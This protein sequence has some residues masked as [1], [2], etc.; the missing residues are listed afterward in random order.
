MLLDK[1]NNV[2]KTVRNMLLTI[3]NPNG[4]KLFTGVEQGR[5]GG[6]YHDVTFVIFYSTMEQEVQKWL[7]RNWGRRY[8]V[9]GFH[10]PSQSHSAPPST[11]TDLEYEEMLKHT[12]EE[13]TFTAA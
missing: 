1:T 7:E 11:K 2:T 12:N 10:N 4:H 3:T 5:P 6:E 13:I 8:L 9:N